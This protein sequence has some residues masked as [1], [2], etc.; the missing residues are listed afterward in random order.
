MGLR[1]KLNESAAPTRVGLVIIVIA[2]FAFV[3]WQLHGTRAGNYIH[4]P[5]YFSDDD[6]KTYFVDDGT[7]D[8]PFDHNGKQAVRALV[9]K[10]GNGQPFV[11]ALEKYSDALLAQMHPLSPSQMGSGRPDWANGVL[12]KKPGDAKWVPA[13]SSEGMDI[14]QPRC[15]NGSNDKPVQVLP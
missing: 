6:G 14:Q 10:C 8:V 13:H 9:F 12:V 3:L 1:E 7:L 15:P 11:G 2:I 4:K 5:G